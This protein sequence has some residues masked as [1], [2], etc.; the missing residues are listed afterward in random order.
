MK[1]DEE[2]EAF[3]ITMTNHSIKVNQVTVESKHTGFPAFYNGKGGI[4]V[5]K[6]DDCWKALDR[7]VERKKL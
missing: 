2:R 7:L 4:T 1:T 3:K 5:N 6:L